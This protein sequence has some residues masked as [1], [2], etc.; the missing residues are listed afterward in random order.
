MRRAEDLIAGY[1]HE[2][3]SDDFVRANS[4]LL[5]LHKYYGIIDGRTLSALRS[6]AIR[7]DVMGAWQALDEMVK[8]YQGGKTG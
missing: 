5:V 8:A 1:A 4:F 3:C 7:G 2:P 6:R